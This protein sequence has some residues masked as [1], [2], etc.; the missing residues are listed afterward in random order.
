MTKHALVKQKT[1]IYAGAEGIGKLIPDAGRRDGAGGY[2]IRVFLA[3]GLKS[4]LP[5]LWRK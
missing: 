2:T 5:A 3:G 4:C 1:S